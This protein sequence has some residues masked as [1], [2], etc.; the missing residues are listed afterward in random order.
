MFL[1]KMLEH[2]IT[3]IHSC[4]QRILKL[5]KVCACVCVCVVIRKSLTLHTKTPLFMT[6]FCHLFTPKLNNS[7]CKNPTCNLP[8]HTCLPR[9]L[10]NSLCKNSTSC[11]PSQLTSKHKQLSGQ[12]YNVIF[13][14]TPMFTPNLSNCLGKITT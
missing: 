14:I 13:T 6:G 7:L 4:G 2:Y 5:T 8:S 1:Q 11:F 12:N 3:A 10:N 9:N